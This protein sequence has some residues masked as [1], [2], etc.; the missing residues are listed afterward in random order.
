[1]ESQGVCCVY[2][3]DRVCRV[4][5]GDEFIQKLWDIHLK[6]KEEGYTQVP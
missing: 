2:V 4:A 1:M 5:D 3:A 6:V